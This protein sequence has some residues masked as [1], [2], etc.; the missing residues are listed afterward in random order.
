M[1]IN[2]LRELILVTGLIVFCG[3]VWWAYL[4]KRRDRFDRAARSVLED[5]DRDAG[6]RSADERAGRER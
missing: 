4:P 1:D 6:I 3:I 2:F 5:D